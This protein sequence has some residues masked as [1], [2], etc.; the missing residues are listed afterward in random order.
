MV[1][2]QIVRPLPAFEKSRSTCRPDWCRQ[3]TAVAGKEAEEMRRSRVEGEEMK[4]CTV[5]EEM[6]RCRVGAEEMRRSW[7]EGEEMKRSRVEGEE[8]KRWSRPDW[9]RQ[10]TVAAEM[11]TETLL[12]LE[13]RQA[14]TLG[15]LGLGRWPGR[16]PERSR[17]L[18]PAP[19]PEPGPTPGKGS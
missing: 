8:M 4:R 19:E 12:P 17:P 16:R 14:G 9:C 3:L 18:G 6:K 10:L 7:L 15:P 11:Q 2:A 5:E 13:R 1:T